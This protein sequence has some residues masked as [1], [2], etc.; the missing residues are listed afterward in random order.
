MDRVAL[1]ASTASALSNK[2]PQVVAIPA[3]AA[4]V[5]NFRLFRLR[6]LRFFNAIT[7]K[8]F[9]LLSG[10]AILIKPEIRRFL[11]PEAGI[12]ARIHRYGASLTGEKIGELQRR[13]SQK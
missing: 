2:G 13:V 6:I 4:R 8:R 1:C 9:R 11:H 10:Y 3:P 5:M 7:V 12:S